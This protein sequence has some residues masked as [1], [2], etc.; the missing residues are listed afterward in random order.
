MA[1]EEMLEL[2]EATWHTFTNEMWASNDCYS[3][4]KALSDCMW[5]SFT[6]WPMIFQ[7]SVALLS[8]S[9]SED[10]DRAGKYSSWPVQNLRKKEKKLLFK[11][12]LQNTDNNSNT[13]SVV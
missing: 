11:Q 6:L 7:M 1:E 12:Q 5:F 8:Q 2:G 13:T 3:W 4:A 10:D 9:W